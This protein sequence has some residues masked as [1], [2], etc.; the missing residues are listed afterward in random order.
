MGHAEAKDASLEA[1]ADND[2]GVVEDTASMGLDEVAHMEGGRQ[3]IV[4]STAD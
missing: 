2:Q 1:E 4:H 3:V